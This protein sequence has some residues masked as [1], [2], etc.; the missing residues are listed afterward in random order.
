MDTGVTCALGDTALQA[1]YDA[2]EEKCRGNLQRFGGRTVLVEGGG[3]EKVWL[4]TQPMGGEMYAKRN[5]EVGL[6]NQWI[7]MEHQRADGRLPGSVKLEGGRPVPEY[8]KLQGFCFAAPALN[9][10]YLAGRDRRYLLALRDALA[11]FDGYLWRTRACDEGC[12]AASAY[13]T[14]GRITPCAT[15][16]R[17]SGGE[18]KLRPKGTG[19]CRCV[20]WTVTAYSYAARAALA[21]IG[22]IC[23]DGSA[24]GWHRK[25]EAVKRR[26]GEYFWNGERGTCFDR[27]PDGRAQTVLAHNTLR[28]MYWRALD[29]GKAARFVR[30]HLMNP[31]EFYTPAPLPSVAANDPLFRNVPPTTGAASRR[32]S[33]TSGRSV[34]LKITASGRKSHFWGESSSNAQKGWRRVSPAVRPLHGAAGRG[35]RRRL[36]AT[37]LSLLEYVSRLYGVHIEREEVRF[38][39]MARTGVR[40]EQRVGDRRYAVESDGVRARVLVDGKPRWACPCGACVV[41]DVNGDLRRVSVID[42][43]APGTSAP[44]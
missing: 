15:A 20:P 40:Y 13:A 36:R 35:Q 37:M 16:T 41:T 19:R 14:R 33:P 23:R 5:L 9:L 44:K 8:N 7:F 38:G 27:G 34:R 26:I 28:L 30:E 29:A 24:Q 17:P 42:P 2:A 12:C 32:G 4:E 43:D 1:L 25:A 21:D 31:D 3:Y 18:R 6:A 22:V 39:L 10:Y 11:A